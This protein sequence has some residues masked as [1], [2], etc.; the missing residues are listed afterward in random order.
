M[1]ARWGARLA[2]QTMVDWSALVAQWLQP[3]CQIMRRQLLAGDYVQCDET[4]LRCHDPDV[5]GETVA[6]WLWAVSRPRGDVVFEW[7]MSLR[8][9]EATTLLA[10]FKGVLQSDAYPA[11]VTF[12]REHEGVVCVGCW[13]HARR[14]F[15]EALEEA[16]G[17][18]SFVL[19]L[20][21]HLYA[22]EAQWDAAGWTEGK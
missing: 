16:P 7:R 4:P 19:R 10:G 17:P 18:A 11:Y 22:M 1:A 9:A 20:I 15:H 8:Q 21:G 2:R 3:I 5:R 14:R 6:D 12:A 13:A